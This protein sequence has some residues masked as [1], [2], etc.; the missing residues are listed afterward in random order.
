VVRVG[1]H[2]PADDIRV[3]GRAARVGELGTLHDE[4]TGALG[5]HETVAPLVERAAR[6]GRVGPATGERPRV[7]ERVGECGEQRGLAAPAHHHVR[8][9]GA[10]DPQPFG[11]RLRTGRARGADRRAV[12]AQPVLD[13]DPRGAH[14]GQH[15][16]QQ[17]R[18]D[19][20]PALPGARDDLRLQRREA[21]GAGN[22]TRH[23][24][25]VDVPPDVEAGVGDRDV[26]RPQRHHDV[27]VDDARL[28]R[29]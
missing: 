3:P 12:P 15:A 9:V 28:G 1:R 22:D 14:V 11:D 29:R 5:Q 4:H 21:T 7:A 16:R 8:F 26:R 24:V 6:L 18:A 13:G 23:P 25:R 27:P 20:E 10:Q 2:A 17:V 19:P